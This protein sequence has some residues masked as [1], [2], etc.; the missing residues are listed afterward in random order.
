[1]C[2]KKFAASLLALIL[3]LG[4]CAAAISEETATV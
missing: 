3:C 1:M 4:L 2:M